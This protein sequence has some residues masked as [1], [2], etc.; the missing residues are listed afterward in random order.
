MG[1]SLYH[2]FRGK[3]EAGQARQAQD[4]L[5]WMTAADPGAQTLAL[6]AWSLARSDQG[7]GVSV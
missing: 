7:K 4:W 5:V 1:V 3:G 2:H 6:V